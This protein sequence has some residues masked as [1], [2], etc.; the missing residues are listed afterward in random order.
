MTE[1][2]RAVVTG[3]SGGIGRA[4]A[5]H[6]AA[7]GASVAGTFRGDDDAREAF[8]SEIR[9]AGGRALLRSVDVSD[10]AAVVAF[11]NEAADAFGGIDF[12][13]NNAARLMVKPFLETTE[14]DWSSLFSINF[15][16]YVWGC[17]VA[18]QHMTRQQSGSI[19][20]VSSVVFEQPPTDLSAYVSAKGAVT[21]L[22]RAL[23]VELGP[24]GIVV[25]AVS[26]GATDTPLNDAAWTDAVRENYLKRI[27]ARR[28]GSPEEVAAAVALL[29]DP[30]A[31]Y[32]TGQVIR[33]DGGL[34]L[35]GSVGHEQ[36]P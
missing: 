31:R 26:P 36:T 9:D 33:A 25:N 4:L 27:P 30:G 6:L 22:T 16:G 15:L 12:W 3:A 1:P 28:I 21:G 2:L 29:A 34:V 32:V 35:D 14:D 20:N 19:V 11:G 7:R 24:A 8:A 13:V 18:A 17:Q 5:L 10:R 23:A